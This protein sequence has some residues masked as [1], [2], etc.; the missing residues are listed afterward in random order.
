MQILN[1]SVMNRPAK[2]LTS[3]MYVVYLP[4]GV[5]HSWSVRDSTIQDVGNLYNLKTTFQGTVTL[6]DSSIRDVVNKVK[7]DADTFGHTLGLRDSTI[8]DTLNKFNAGVYTFTHTFNMRD[9]S[10]STV[11]LTYKMEPQEFS[12]SFSIRD[13]TL[14]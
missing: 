7:V 9:S 13:S 12:Q 4:V 8:S 11:L 14:E 3:L 5:N 2:S 6:G 1:I 10:I